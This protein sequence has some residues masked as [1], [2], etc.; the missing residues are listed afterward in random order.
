MTRFA[1]RSFEP[2]AIALDENGPARPAGDL[3]IVDRWIVS[4]LDAVTESATNL[5]ERHLYGEAGRQVAD[6]LWGEVADWYIEVAKVRLRDEGAAA[7]QVGQVI[8]YVLERSLRLLHPYMPFITEALWQQL[9][10]TGDSIMVAA[11]PEAGPRDETAEA[12]VGAMMELVRGIRN[13]R[14][15]AGVEPAKW[16]SASIYA[17]DLLD[18]FGQM[19]GEIAF[20][21]RIDG[22]QLELLEGKPGETGNAIT[23]VA[24]DVVALLP[25]EDMVDLGAE[26]ERL[27]KELDEARLE[28]QRAEKQ[29]ANESFVSRA[30][31]HVVRVQRERLERAQEQIA[32][33]EQRLS[34]LDG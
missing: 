10:H 32:I 9:P 23:V 17:G 3:D 21:A 34:A 5:M 24:G 29:L 1:L 7:K 30:P 16:I 13:A 20:L 11:W 33:I 27:S 28:Q 6:F 18:A 31:E 2:E 12:Q 26:R 15:E 19:R 4:R 8:A 14:T 22:D 25:L